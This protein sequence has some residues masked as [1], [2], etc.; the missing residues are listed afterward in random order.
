[1][2]QVQIVSA[3]DMDFKAYW[4]GVRAAYHQWGN[5]KTGY[6]DYFPSVSGKLDDK[7]LAEVLHGAKQSGLSLLF[8]SAVRKS[9][10]EISLFISFPDTKNNGLEMAEKF[11]DYLEQ[12]GFAYRL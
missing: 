7:S 10:E 5:D 12:T 8:W 3:G 6:T 9:D 2:E 4:D 1:M 11:E